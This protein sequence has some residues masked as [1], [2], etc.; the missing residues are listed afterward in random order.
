MNKKKPGFTL[1]ELLI[2][3]VIVGVIAVLVLI[4]FSN[5]IQKKKTLTKV[6]I[7]YAQIYQAIRLAEAD[8]GPIGDWDLKLYA[9]GGNYYNATNSKKVFNMYFRPYLKTA[10]VCGQP[11][12]KTECTAG[13]DHAYN[14]RLNSGATVNFSVYPHVPLP[15]ETWQYPN[16]NSK[17]YIRF[18]LYIDGKVKKYVSGVNTFIFDT[19]GGIFAPAGYYPGISIDDIKAGKVS[20]GDWTNGRKKIY[21]NKN[22]RGACT[23]YL[24]LNKWEIPKD[25]PW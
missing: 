6:K 18:H 10:A 23:L 22:N 21:C 11:G 7:S 14:F 25:Y 1:A 4:P 13:T 16:M 8:F 24:Y 17:Y 19:D 12:T 3:L 2:A 20:S 5:K 15:T 9:S